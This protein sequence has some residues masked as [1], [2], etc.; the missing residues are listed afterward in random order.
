M[1][2][3]FRKPA[4]D[5][6]VSTADYINLKIDEVK[7]RTAKGL[8]LTLNRLFLALLFFHLGSIVLT[9]LGF[10]AILLIGD[11]VGSYSAGAFIVAGAFLLVIALLWAFRG[12]LFLN[13]LIRLFIGIFFSDNDNSDEIQ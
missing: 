5:L 4:E 10:G 8:S 1:E 3:E 13:G 7:L 9:A 2:N 12:R 11:L 6:A